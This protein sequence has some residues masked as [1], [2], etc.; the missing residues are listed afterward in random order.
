MFEESLV[1]SGVRAMPMRTR[2]TAAVS[3]TVQ[4]AVASLLIVVPML[5]TELLPERRNALTITVPVTTPPPPPRTVAQRASSAVASVVPVIGRMLVAPRTLPN[6]IDSSPELTDG[7][8]VLRMGLA[9]A[10]TGLYDVLGGPAP[11]VRIAV[12][13]EK[14]AGPVHVSSGVLAGLL[15]TPIRPVYPP[16]AKA[17]HVEGTVVVEAVISKAGTIESLR[18]ASGPAMLQPAALEAVRAARYQPFRLN[19]EP[20]EVQTTITVNFKMGS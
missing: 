6:R 1:E 15:L 16:I 4:A 14:K 7:Q 8:P 19:G 17:A 3:L 20:T 9:S 10:S 18:V 2:W 5:R 13:P 11:S 12:A